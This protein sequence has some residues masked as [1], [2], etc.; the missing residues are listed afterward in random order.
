MDV[1]EAPATLILQ[2]TEINVVQ[3]HLLVLNRKSPGIKTNSLGSEDSI[4]RYRTI[5]EELVRQIMVWASVTPTTWE[6]LKSSMIWS[7]MMFLV[8]GVGNACRSKIGCA[9]I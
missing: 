6:T 2:N 3:R 5:L 4:N 8:V 1:Y 9:C 7:S